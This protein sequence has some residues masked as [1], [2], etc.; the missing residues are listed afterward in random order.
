MEELF[1]DGTSGGRIRETLA[2]YHSI[3]TIILADDN[4][5][6]LALLSNQEA[7]GQKSDSG[8]AVEDDMAEYTAMI[9]YRISMEG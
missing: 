3:T 5:S 4:I 1:R 2:L 7:R 9:T 8:V 6:Q